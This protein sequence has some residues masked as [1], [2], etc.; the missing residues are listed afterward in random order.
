MTTFV[1]SDHAM[2]VATAMIEALKY[3]L[4]MLVQQVVYRLTDRPM[5]Y[6]TIK[7]T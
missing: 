2:R 1:D 7:V 3:K 6:V 5:Y 4:R